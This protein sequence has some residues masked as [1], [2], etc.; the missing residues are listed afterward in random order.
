MAPQFALAP[1]IDPPQD[2]RSGLN[3]G[4]S[5]VVPIIDVGLVACVGA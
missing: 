2:L 4:L 5:D 3:T 1:P